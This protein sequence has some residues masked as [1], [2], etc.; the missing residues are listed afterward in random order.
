MQIWEADFLVSIS[1]QKLK[2]ELELNGNPFS[3]K[4]GNTLQDLRFSKL[5]ACKKQRKYFSQNYA[6][7]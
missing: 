1:P 7:F 2:N 5:S 6:T 3:S 4:L